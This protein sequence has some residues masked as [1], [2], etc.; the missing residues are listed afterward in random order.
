MLKNDK[1]NIFSLA[2]KNNFKR[3][4]Y[5]KVTLRDKIKYDI[6]L[7]EGLLKVFDN[8]EQLKHIIYACQTI[9]RNEQ[10]VP[11]KYN[12]HFMSYKPIQRTYDYE[13]STIDI[14]IE[15]SNRDFKI[16]NESIPNNREI[17]ENILY[18]ALEY[19]VYKYDLAVSGNDFIDTAE[20]CV[21]SFECFCYYRNK[22]NGEYESGN[23]II[24]P[25][26]SLIK[27]TNTPNLTFQNIINL[28]IPVW[29]FFL[30]K[31]KYLYLI[32]NNLECV[33]NASIAIEAYIIY[34]IKKNDKYEKYKKE[35]S[36]LGFRVA[37]QFA[38]DNELM[39]L[40]EAELFE[41]GYDNICL[42]RSLI[43]HG[44]IDTP[45]ID[46]ASAK[47]VYETIIDIFIDIDK[48]LE[49]DLSIEN[50]YFESDFIQM[51]NIVKKYD[52]ED[53][54]SAITDL[55]LNIENNIFCDLSTFYRA[56]CLSKLGKSDEAIKDFKLCIENK[57]RLIECYNCLGME[58]SKIGNH[59]EAKNTYLDGIKLDSTYPEYYYNLG[60]EQHFLKEYD[61]AIISYNKALKLRECAC[62]YYNL[63][64]TYY[65]K[66]DYDNVLKYYSKAIQ[67]EP[68]NSQYL[69]ERAFMYEMLKE[70]QK[71]EKDIVKC[72]K[73]YKDIP[74]IAFIRERIY[75]IGVLYQNEEKYKDAIRMFSRGCKIDN[76]SHAFYQAR[77]NCYR[78]LGITEKARK[79]YDKSLELSSRSYNDLINL[80]YLYL[81]IGDIENASSFFEEL[82]NK[83]SEINSVKNCSDIFYFNCYQQ[84]KISLKE[85]LEIFKNNHE[86]IE[87]SDLY[88]KLT[89]KFG[90]IE[91]NKFL[92]I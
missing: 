73:Y 20:L 43:V 55:N 81:D 3:F 25:S 6:E 66:N 9:M 75:Q 22:K 87:E 88:K 63:G 72:L 4:V 30:N 77:G 11:P 37:L 31:A 61:E 76:K 60:I 14:L 27:S 69:Y 24:S 56:K 58:L 78:A 10:S 16:I 52:D 89:S 13:T 35:N 71:A 5:F 44:A 57:Y 1:F 65:Y 33:M 83:Y 90:K 50:K 67:L 91:T 28:D 64:V 46:R 51:D 41:D 62:Y 74:N 26:M 82:E 45:I 70:P 23:C 8:D 19:F 54:S 48:K 92:Q 17:I 12:N 84:K 21:G 36:N 7:V 39:D 42:Q 79:D 53:F 80:T 38:K 86:N 47:K 68:N 15:C 18:K 32:H 34:I 40:R 85:F 29:K 59:E 2:K 49:K